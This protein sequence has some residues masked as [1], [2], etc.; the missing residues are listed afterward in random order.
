MKGVRER[1]PSFCCPSA[2]H[3]N[4]RTRSGGPRVPRSQAG[5]DMR[6]S[7]KTL[8]IALLA[9]PA[10]RA[11]HEVATKNVIGSGVRPSP[12]LYNKSRANTDI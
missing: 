5:P 10:V 4:I 7:R 6:V 11:V 1:K 9:L 2:L 12:V 3:G 8:I